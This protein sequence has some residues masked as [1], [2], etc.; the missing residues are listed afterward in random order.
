MMYDVKTD[1]ARDQILDTMLKGAQ[2][3]YDSFLGYSAV[4]S[5]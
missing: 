1:K 2:Y 5:R 3:E 4:W